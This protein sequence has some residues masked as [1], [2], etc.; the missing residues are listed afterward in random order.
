VREHGSVRHDDLR[1]RSLRRVAL[2]DEKVELY[3]AGLRDR[4][5][6]GK[7]LWITET[8]DAACGGNPWASTF[9]DS[10]RYLNQLGSMAQHDVQVVAHNTLDASD[11]GL[12]D[13]NTL[14]PRPNYWAALLWRKLMGTTVLNPAVPRT[15]G[16]HVYAHCL[17]DTSG[18][19][20]IL[21]INAN[22]AASQSIRLPMSAERY[23]LTATTL[24]STQV[25]LNGKQLDLGTDDA[26]P[27]L[28]GTHIP[29]G[30]IT[31]SPA[32]ITFLAIPDAHKA[33]CSASH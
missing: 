29:S 10:F 31:F 25:Q 32:S 30:L 3:Y 24:M 22:R 27:R 28:Q 18:G 1:C 12:L 6:P 26:L 13:E 15:P 19:V 23:T 11:Y 21:A 7:P 8:A 33:N 16:L 4:Y 2:Q 5:D 17:R 20:A 14:M 9:L